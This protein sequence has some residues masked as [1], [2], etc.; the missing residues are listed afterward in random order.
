[1]V[2]WLLMSHFHFRVHFT[3]KLRRAERRHDDDDD[4]DDDDQEAAEGRRGHR[5]GDRKSFCPRTSLLWH[6]KRTRVSFAR[7]PRSDA[8]RG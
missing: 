4:Q 2:S 5:D 1:M 8:R 6:V 7:S 3:G